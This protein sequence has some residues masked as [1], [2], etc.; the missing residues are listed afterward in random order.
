MAERRG[1]VVQPRL[2][3]LGGAVGI[4]F[5][6]VVLVV[7]PWLLTRH[8]QRGVTAEQA[9]KAKN[10]VRTTLVQALAGLAVAG[11]L[12]VTYST[13]RQNQRDGLDDGGGAAWAATQRL[14]QGLAGGW[15][16]RFAEGS[17]L[18]VVPVDG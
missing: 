17:A 10:D 14:G 15:L 9:L 12:V 5:V 7:G 13:Y 18:G 4:F 2:W 8:P 16:W 11:G 3:A 6:V 1:R